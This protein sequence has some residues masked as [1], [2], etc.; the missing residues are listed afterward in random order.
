MLIDGP[1]VDEL[2]DNY[3]LRGSSNQKIYIIDSSL[4]ERY[5]KYLTLP[6]SFELSVSGKD[7]V[8]IGLLPKD[9]EKYLH[10]ILSDD[11]DTPKA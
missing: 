3:P 7:V 2:N 5:K 1:Y 4:T 10:E 8:I 11:N 6:R 9:G